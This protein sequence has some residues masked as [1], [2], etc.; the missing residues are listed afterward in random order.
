MDHLIP[1]AEDVALVWMDTQGFEGQIFKGGRS[2]FSNDIPV[3]VEM[4]P[5]GIQ[6][7]GMELEEFV[8]VVTELWPV[9]C[10]NTNGVYIKHSIGE[11]RGFLDALDVEASGGFD[12]VILLK[13]FECG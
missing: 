1:S 10:V 8:H 7:S 6:R 12:D 3:N 11:L 5:Y 4:W 13:A 2:L 9:F